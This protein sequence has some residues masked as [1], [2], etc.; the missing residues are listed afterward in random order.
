M[1]VRKHSLRSQ[2]QLSSTRTLLKQTGVSQFIR[3]EFQLPK[4]KKPLVPCTTIIV[5]YR[6]LAVIITDNEIVVQVAG[7]WYD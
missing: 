2:P 4:K 7:F 6:F 1:H 5:I 3:V